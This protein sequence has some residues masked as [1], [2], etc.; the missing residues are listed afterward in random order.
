MKNKVFLNTQTKLLSNVEDV[1]IIEGYANA[2]TKD[3]DGD[4]VIQYGIDLTNFKKNPIMLYQHDRNNPIGKVVAVEATDKGLY[5]KCE[6]YKALNPQAYAGVV[7]GVLK[8]FSI[9]FRGLDGEYN[10]DTDT[11]Y[12]TKSELLEVSV[13]SIPAN[14]DSIFDL[15]ES[16]CGDGF[17]LL[18]KKG[19]KPEGSI[20]K[21]IQAKEQ[22]MS[23]EVVKLLEEIAKSNKELLALQLEKQEQAKGEE[24]P[25]VEEAP[26]VEEKEF[27]L[28]AHIEELEVKEGQFEALLKAQEKLSAK[29]NKFVEENI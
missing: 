22:D 19:Y 16:P 5:V 27:N 8:T 3:R 23:E 29:L 6:I 13:V 4:I 20:K 12:F 9:G 28:V 7:N 10:D 15:V 26:E 21:E 1:A 2:N 24:T 11:F 17:C 25:E 18:G 14:Q